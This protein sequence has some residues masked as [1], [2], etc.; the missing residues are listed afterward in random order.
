MV[1]MAT[2]VRG[3]ARCCAKGSIA[4]HRTRSPSRAAT[5]LRWRAYGE[6]GGRGAHRSAALQG[7]PT[8]DQGPLRRSTRAIAV[9]GLVHGLEG[10]GP[11]GPAEAKATIEK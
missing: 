1:G 10:R 6:G 3:C 7:A 8:R 11:S 2:P 5:D 9:H 4:I